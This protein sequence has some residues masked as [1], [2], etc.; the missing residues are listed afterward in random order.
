MS[1]EITKLYHGTRRGFRKGGI[2]LP[3]RETGSCSWEDYPHDHSAVYLT[4][5][6]TVA[7]YFATWSKGRGRPKIVEVEAHGL[8]RFDSFILGG[9]NYREI[10]VDWATVIG[11][12]TL[13]A[14]DLVGAAQWQMNNL[15]VDLS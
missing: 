5:D 4:E 11:V 1:D 14:D 13:T 2:L 6:P 12:R 3:C 7:A 10:M 9:E 15:V 8:M